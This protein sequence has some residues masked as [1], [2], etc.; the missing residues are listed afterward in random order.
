MLRTR[1]IY[2]EAVFQPQD[3]Y[4]EGSEDED[5]DDAATRK[6]RYDAAGQQFLAGKAPLLLSATLKGPFEEESGWVN[7]W[8]SKNRT[9][10]SQH[11]PGSQHAGSQYSHKRPA[12]SAFI[13][14]QAV[15]ALKSAE[16]ALPSPESLKQAPFTEAHSR[17]HSKD[18]VVHDWRDDVSSLPLDNGD[19]WA[20]NSPSR[21]LNKRKSKSSTW[22]NSV[23]NKRQ[24][25]ES[26]ETEGE[27]P[28][29]GISQTPKTNVSK[30]GTRSKT[31]VSSSS[32]YSHIRE[33]TSKLPPGGSQD[34][35]SEDEDTDD[36]SSD[37]A[38]IIP[39]STVSPSTK[40]SLPCTKGSPY[41]ILRENGYS[42]SPLSSPF[43]Q[44]S[45]LRALSPVSMS[46]AQTPTKRAATTKASSRRRSSSGLSA[47]SDVLT[48]LSSLSDLDMLGADDGDDDDDTGSTVLPGSQPREEQL[49]SPEIP[50]INGDGDPIPHTAL[51][52]DS[53]NEEDMPPFESNE[54]GPQIVEDDVHMDDLKPSSDIHRG[55][56]TTFRATQP[57]RMASPLIYD[58]AERA[59]Q[60]VP[61]PSNTAL[62]SSQYIATDENQPVNSSTFGKPQPSGDDNVAK[63][64]SPHRSSPLQSLSPRNGRI[65]SRPAL[66]KIVQPYFS[67][68]HDSSNASIDEALYLQLDD[69]QQSKENIE[70]KEVNETKGNPTP[71][72]VNITLP[73]SQSSIN[74]TITVPDCV[75]SPSELD[76]S[77]EE[78]VACDSPVLDTED[79][80]QGSLL[81]SIL[82]QAEPLHTPLTPPSTSLPP[83]I[84]TEDASI[85]MLERQTNENASE[86][87]SEPSL[88]GPVT[89][90]HSCVR[91]QEQ[92]DDSPTST[93]AAESSI[94]PS[95]GIDAHHLLS[96][97][98]P[99][100]MEQ[101]LRRPSTPEPQFAFTSFSSFMSPSP[102]HRRQTHHFSNETLDGIA[103]K[104]QGI[105]MTS[106]KKSW[107]STIPKKRVSWAPLPHEETAMSDEKASSETEMSSSL[108]RGRDRAG[109]PPPPSTGISSDSLAQGD[110]KFGD[111]F[112]AVADGSKGTQ[113]QK[114]PSTP[115]ISER[116][117]SSPDREAS[118]EKF[119]TEQTEKK[120][121]GTKTSGWDDEDPTDIVEDMFNEMDDF[122]Q[123]W[124]VDAELNEARKADKAR[125]SSKRGAEMVPEDDD[126][127]MS[128]SFSIL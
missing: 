82:G 83:S 126:I 21:K 46:P 77:Q 69:D 113:P 124:D 50:E 121:F 27:T 33:L 26:V 42:S 96:E 73:A 68:L 100:S 102:N 101:V 39:S 84:P 45:L 72:V 93:R 114:V 78:S 60:P 6:Q 44:P 28:T 54:N 89:D 105:L 85:D 29:L 19:F 7:P 5:Y 80:A 51:A 9:S 120:S 3:I 81:P 70:A 31:A 111:H 58:D 61:E 123:V 117:S 62:L 17:L 109:S 65:N 4:Y 23:T 106:M 75:Q 30:R 79:T 90:G 1:S 110:A 36:T 57:S 49:V 107:R 91:Q 87:P 40:A 122:L 20:T 55:R 22:L 14:K 15:D 41:R 25:T 108:S 127:D 13:E 10:H 99:K 34:L 71:S 43:S 47:L 35:S 94:T 16:F 98:S 74:E 88:I 115:S 59:D 2:C 92:Q 64:T 67:S 104:S 48:S 76:N 12:A 86:T 112:A 97:D 95:Q 119:A 53:D 32:I 63:G 18:D 11:Q 38:V 128:A 37:E 66:K 103:P 52:A 125:T 8:R 118:V 24:K 56:F 116:T